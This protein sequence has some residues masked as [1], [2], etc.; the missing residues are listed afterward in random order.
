MCQKLFRQDVTNILHE[1]VRYDHSSTN[2]GYDIISQVK[3]YRIAGNLFSSLRQLKSEG[4]M[5]TLFSFH[6]CVCSLPRSPSFHSFF[7]SSDHDVIDGDDGDVF[8]RWRRRRRDSRNRRCTAA[9][10]VWDCNFL[11]PCRRRRRYRPS[12]PFLPPVLRRLV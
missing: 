11:P 10:S 4:R 12:L 6:T 8:L 7:L 3:C 9:P 1:D 2:P 5:N